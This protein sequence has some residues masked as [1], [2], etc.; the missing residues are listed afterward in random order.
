MVLQSAAMGPG[1]QTLSVNFRVFKIALQA[2][3]EFILSLLIIFHVTKEKLSKVGSP[4]H[5]PTSQ[6]LII[7]SQAAWKS[8]NC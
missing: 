4:H 1:K 8:A 7:A 3:S 2:S 5:P 6:V